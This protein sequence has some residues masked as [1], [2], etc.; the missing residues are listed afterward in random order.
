MLTKSQ[1]KLLETLNLMV[2]EMAQQAARIKRLEDQ[3]AQMQAA[4]RRREEQ[5]VRGVPP[6]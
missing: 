3:V 6:R 5:R 1:E 2:D 4:E